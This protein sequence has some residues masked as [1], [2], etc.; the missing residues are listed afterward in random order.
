VTGRKLHI[1]ARRIFFVTKEQTAKNYASIAAQGKGEGHVFSVFLN[2]RNPKIIEAP[3][4]VDPIEFYDDHSYMLRYVKN[5]RKNGFIVRGRT[6]VVYISH[7]NRS[8]S[9]LWI[10][11]GR[12]TGMNRIFTSSLEG[13]KAPRT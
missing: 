13:A 4:E 5:E 3:S 8:K 1:W 7:L 2:L 9:S 11:V 12:G 10:T 6:R